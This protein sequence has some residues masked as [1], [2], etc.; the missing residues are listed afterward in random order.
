MQKVPCYH[1][2]IN[3]KENESPPLVLNIWGTLE[4]NAACSRLFYNMHNIKPALAVF[5]YQTVW[6]QLK[7]SKIITV[8]T[9]A[10][11]LTK[12]SWQEKTTSVNLLLLSSV[13]SQEWKT[14]LMFVCF[15]EHVNIST[16]GKNTKH[17]SLQM[18]WGQPWRTWRQEKLRGSTSVCII[19][20]HASPQL[21]KDFIS[22][23]IQTQ[24]KLW[25]FKN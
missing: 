5:T 15:H 2:Q 21:V 25:N 20:M 22:L 17:P 9:T 1:A 10:G 13:E 7:P 23:K 16:S 18:S 4:N 11:Q 6:L 14:W 8:V 3:P 19:S 12:P 24:T